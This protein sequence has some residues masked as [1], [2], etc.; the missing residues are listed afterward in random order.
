MARD[1]RA[2][3]SQKRGA[4]H[5]SFFLTIWGQASSGVVGLKCA[6]AAQTAA[7]AVKSSTA[8]V[9]PQGWCY[10]RP[11][12]GCYWRQQQQQQRKKM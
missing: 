6:C 1:V 7:A 9:Q 2:A 5:R 8:A 11:I 3:P 12:K 10:E 4:L